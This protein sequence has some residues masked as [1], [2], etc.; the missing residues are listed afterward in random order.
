MSKTRILIIEGDTDIAEHIQDILKQKGHEV[1]GVASSDNEAL[2]LN[3]KYKPDLLLADSASNDKIDGLKT[4]TE[5]KKIRDIPVIIAA[6]KVNKTR[7]SQ[8]KEIEPHGFLLKPVTTE[9]IRDGL[10]SYLSRD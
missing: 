6:S 1:I 2:S 3:E 10:K 4:A 7:I 5:I 8:V 9:S